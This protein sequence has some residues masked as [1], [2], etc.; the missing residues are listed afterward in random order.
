MVVHAAPV[1]PSTV[2]VAVDVGKTECAFSV[3]EVDTLARGVR[4]V[5]QAVQAEQLD[6]PVDHAEDDLGGLGVTVVG[7]GPVRGLDRIE[8]L[9]LQGAVL[10]TR[11]A[12]RR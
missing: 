3:T 8:P 7:F 1:T 4:A 12:A 2:V 6:A 9:E 5:G 11:A 10:V